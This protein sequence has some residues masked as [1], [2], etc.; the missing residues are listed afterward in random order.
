MASTRLAI[1]VRRGLML[2]G[3]SAVLVVSLVAMGKLSD[4]AARYQRKAE[5]FDRL[6]RWALGEAQRYRALEEPLRDAAARFR[7]GEWGLGETKEKVHFD[8]LVKTM[9]EANDEALLKRET[10]KYFTLMAKEN[11]R[12]ADEYSKLNKRFAERA[13]FF[14]RLRRKYERATRAPWWSVS[15]DPPEPD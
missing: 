9:R 7:R 12:L 1:T 13:A 11:E 10:D 15:P 14:G 4:N 6:E 8:N 2:L 5:N 3:V